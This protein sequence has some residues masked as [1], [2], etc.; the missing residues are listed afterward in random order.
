MSKKARRRT[1]IFYLK[2]RQYEKLSRFTLSG[3][4]NRGFVSE[5]CTELVLQELVEKSFL[6][7]FYRTRRSGPLDQRGIDFI[8]TRRKNGNIIKKYFGI[9]CSAIRCDHSQIKHKIPQ[10]HLSMNDTQED[11]ERKLKA[12]LLI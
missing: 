3:K 12:F 4:S 9:S 6:M 5:A 7:S 2:T 11:I 8:T 10:L 1:R